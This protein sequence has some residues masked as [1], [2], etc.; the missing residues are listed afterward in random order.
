MRVKSTETAVKFLRD[1][2]LDNCV[3][4]VIVKEG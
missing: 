3:N 4:G 2:I 1:G